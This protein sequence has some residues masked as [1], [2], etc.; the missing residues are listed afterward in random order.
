MP[1]S[2]HS[3]SDDDSNYLEPLDYRRRIPPDPPER[4][5]PD[6]RAQQKTLEDCAEAEGV[7]YR[8]P[9]HERPANPVVRGSQRE[10][11]MSDLR[12]TE[13]KRSDYAFK[14]L[15]RILRRVSSAPFASK[16]L[17]TRVQKS[18][19][20][21]TGDNTDMPNSQFLLL[22]GLY[23]RDSFECRCKRCCQRAM[24]CIAVAYQDE[25]GHW[26]LYTPCLGCA[27]EKTSCQFRVIGMKRA[28]NNF[29]SVGEAQSVI[30][31]RMEKQQAFEAA[32]SYAPDVLRPLLDKAVDQVAAETEE[33]STRLITNRKGAKR[34]AA[35]RQREREEEERVRRRRQANPGYRAPTPPIP[36][37]S[38]A[39]SGLPSIHHYEPTK[40]R[41]F[42]RRGHETPAEMERLYTENILLDVDSYVGRLQESKLE[43][44]RRTRWPPLV[45]PDQYGSWA[46]SESLLERV[47]R[48]PADGEYFPAESSPPPTNPTSQAPRTDRPGVLPNLI[49]YARR[50]FAEGELSAGTLRAAGFTAAQADAFMAR[51]P[52][53]ED[54]DV[55]A[56]IELLAVDSNPPCSYV[57]PGTQDFQ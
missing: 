44:S 42:M 35:D 57:H 41:Y 45:L 26:Q 6:V 15:L 20:R 54:A 31:D 50:F 40:V 24:P 4:P 36:S 2:E 29:R 55:G 19:N 16:D 18:I 21:M 47:E 46:V 23:D 37:P 43:E 49:S 39:P 25:S 53:E 34:S 3:D 13:V 52:T 1:P 22:D 5:R 51:L 27:L 7:R 9:W 56:A 14:T 11:L 8:T 30:Q 17:K 33:A 10:R 48:P 28:V 32:A 12:G 38:R